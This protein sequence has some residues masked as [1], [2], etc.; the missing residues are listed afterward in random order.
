[1][2]TA[3]VRGSEGKGSLSQK[4]RTVALAA[5]NL[6]PENVGRYLHSHH[7][8]AILRSHRLAMAG[9]REKRTMMGSFQRRPF[10]RYVLGPRVTIQTWCLFTSGSCSSSSAFRLCWQRFASCQKRGPFLVSH[11][12]EVHRVWC[13]GGPRH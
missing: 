11:F 8:G 2:R 13:E 7:T 1:M 9:P 5:V 4:T 12:L 10:P 6:S 3:Q